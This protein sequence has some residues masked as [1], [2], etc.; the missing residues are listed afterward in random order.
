MS[1]EFGARAGLIAADDTTVRISRRP[2]F[3]PQGARW[4]AAVADWRRLPS[5]AGARYDT[6]LVV[7]CDAIAPR[8]TW[9]NSPQD[10]IAVDAPHS[11]AGAVSPTPI[12]ARWR[13]ARCVYMDLVPGRADRGHANRLRLYRLLHQRPA[14]R[15]PEAAAIARGRKV[16]PGV[17]R[18]WSC[19]APT[20]VKRE[21]EADRPRSRCSVA[22]G[23]EWRESACSMCVAANG[24]MVPPGKRSISTTN[25]NFESRQGP[26]QPHPSREPGHGR[27]GGRQRSDHRC[28]AV[29][30]LRETA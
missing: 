30:R 22:A 7:D 8:V 19:P 2:A 16:A 9:G 25:R 1:I 13:S 10:V 3:R 14:V 17:T 21:A 20:T 11:R 23:F 29:A 5:D 12:V 4:D 18:R 28:A 6:E 24:D 27:G 26:A 15:P